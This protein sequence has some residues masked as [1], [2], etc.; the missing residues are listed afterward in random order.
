MVRERGTGNDVLV[1]AFLALGMLAA[2]GGLR[3]ILVEGNWWLQASV[4]VI[5]ILGVAAVVRRLAGIGIWATLAAALAAVAVIT[6]MFAPDAAILRII[7]TPETIDQLRALW[8]AGEQSILVQGVPA[9]A[10]LGIRLF[11]CLGVAALALAGDALAL[12]ARVPALAGVPLVAMLLIPDL[13]RQVT[14]DPVVLGVTMVAY[15]GM[16][17]AARPTV[18]GARGIGVAALTGAVMVV[19][20]AIAA[21]IV[22]PVERTAAVNSGINSTTINPVVDLGADLR[23]G[24]PRLALTYESPEPQYL[25]LVALDEFGGDTWSPSPA[26]FVDRRIDDLPAPTGIG[27][28]ISATS[29]TTEITLGAI[30]SAWLPVPYPVTSISGL[31]GAWWMRPDLRAIGSDGGFAANQAYEVTSLSVVP[32]PE[33]LRAAPEPQGLNRLLELPE[34]LPA[35]VAQ[36]A[37]QLTAGLETDYDRA[38]ALQQYFRGGEF[39][40]SE[41]APVEADYDGSGAEALGAFLELKSGYCVHFSSAMAAMSR[42]LGIPARVAVGFTP[43]VVGTDGEYRVSTHDLHAWPE[44]YFTDIGWV[45]F[46][47]T[48]SRGT[49][50]SFAADAEDPAVPA[51]PAT[52]DEPAEPDETEP[53]DGAATPSPA[54]TVPGDDPLGEENTGTPGESASASPAPLGFLLL[55]FLLPAVVRAVL[56]ALRLSRAREGDAVAA[57][58]ELQAT[59]TDL[60]LRPQFAT[61]ARQF[62]EHLVKATGGRGAE[63]IERLRDA[64]EAKHYAEGAASVGDRSALATDVRQASAAVRRS[65]PAGRVVTAAVLPLSLISRWLR[66]KSER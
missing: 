16:L 35:S 64:V 21:P 50:P 29:I 60:G 61:T 62:A 5:V 34:T 20:L 39:A 44:L 46:E 63:A 3:S 23:R 42:V 17:L 32:T 10:V 55:L 18:P 45:R 37:E 54:P 15:L 26:Q 1:S 6:L 49:V 41:V 7:P 53:D 22:V 36:T 19:V 51:A 56:R 8:T 27:D 57:W 31:D 48:P 43:G 12:Y 38:L 4:V 40:Y 11:I 65:V 58:T 52:P 25:R 47:P 28:D 14:V 30:Q 59:A 24:D 2:L 9:E 33:Q 66:Q 13:I